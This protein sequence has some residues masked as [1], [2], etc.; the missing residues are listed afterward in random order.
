[1]YRAEISAMLAYV[2]LNLVAIATPFAPL[3][4]LI[5][6]LNSPIP[7]ILLF[8]RKMSRLY[9]GEICAILAYFGVNLVA[10]A[11]PFAPLKI[12]IAY[13]NSRPIYSRV[14]GLDVFIELKSVQFWLILA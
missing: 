10:M 13:L 1:M 5:A 14:K 4:I 11:T 3:K 6:H 7:K 2:G 8:P 9:R 12:L